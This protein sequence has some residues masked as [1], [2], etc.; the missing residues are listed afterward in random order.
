MPTP[1]TNVRWLMPGTINERLR[2]AG[3]LDRALELCLAHLRAPAD[4]ELAGLGHEL[5]ARRLVALAHGVRLLAERGARPARE[6]LEGLLGLRAGLRLL[7]VALGR[8]ALLGRGH[9]N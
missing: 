7:D 8:I 9:A 2:L 1:M 4:V 6:V 5:V 3:A